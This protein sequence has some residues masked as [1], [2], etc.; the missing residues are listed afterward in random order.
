MF[1]FEPDSMKNKKRS[2]APA[3]KSLSAGNRKRL[4]AAGDTLSK[5]RVVKNVESDQPERPRVSR[6][7][8]EEME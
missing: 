5:K 6:G 2:I 4:T 1:L 8:D 3:G 7:A